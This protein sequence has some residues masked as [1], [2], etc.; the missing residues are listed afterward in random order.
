M[1]P[2]DELEDRIWQESGL[3]RGQFV[4]NEP[5]RTLAALQE[6]VREVLA[7]H[8]PDL[9]PHLHL[10]LMDNADVLAIASPNGDLFLSTGML[11]RLDD[12]AELQVIL[13]REIAHVMQ[14]HT[15]RTVYAA[16][17]GAGATVVFQAAMNATS[18]IS[19]A[20][21]LTSFQVTPEM[22][23]D[24][25][26]TFIQG[27]LDKLR[28]NMADNLVRRMS[29]T[30]FD[31]MVK[32]SLF[33][34]SE[35]LEGE[36]DDFAL[37]HLDREGLGPA[38]YLR[39]MRRLL[40]EARLDET[41]FSAFYANEGRL[42]DRVKRGEW[43]VAEA[44]KARQAAAVAPVG[45]AA[46]A[47][48]PPASPIAPISPNAPT[49]SALPAV[50]PPPPL[51]A[52]DA[53]ALA[54]I[55]VVAAVVVGDA[56]GDMNSEG[57]AGAPANAGAD[58]RAK[59]Q[60]GQAAPS[61]NLRSEALRTTVSSDT[62]LPYGPLLALVSTPV[63]ASEI[64]AGHLARAVHNLERPRAHI[65]LPARSRLL[66]AESCWASPDP[67]LQG[68]AAAIAQSYLQHAPEDFR[69]L[70]LL[71]VMALRAGHLEQAQDY[72]MRARA[73]APNDDERGF[74]DQYLRRLD[75]KVTAS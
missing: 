22:L 72:L 20:S 12:E 71:G 21:L 33:G 11:L 74:V 69:A 48:A 51:P 34:Y 75:K 67:T 58:A 44:G 46:L 68:R 6:R 16:R 62:D 59:A 55:A 60:E 7:R 45:E 57:D 53:V 14:R 23:V 66:L 3:F 17:L 25:G 38:P 35:S 54:P 40:D 41:K 15:V 50:V 52:A 73:V 5:D 37:A 18:F 56:D 13:A 31:A 10:Y 29:A 4:Q 30:G 61:A 47:L 24:G 32:T 1:Q 39:V 27:Q 2:A 28:Q 19:A 70:R 64:E 36:A 9:A 63:F 43:A 65:D 8:W 26:K 49:P 42:V